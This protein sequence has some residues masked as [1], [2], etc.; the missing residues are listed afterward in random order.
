MTYEGNWGGDPEGWR[1]KAR[2]PS[3]KPSGH[4]AAISQTV[5]AQAVREAIR[6]PKITIYSPAIASY[7]IYLQ[8]TIPRH[9]TSSFLEKRLLGAL[10]NEH[11]EIFDYVVD[12]IK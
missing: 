8:L 3:G 11:R 2:R 12:N 5:L 9:K 1:R 6:F 10:I 7:I 4:G